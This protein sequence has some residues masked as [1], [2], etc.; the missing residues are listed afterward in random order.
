MDSFEAHK[1]NPIEFP[2]FSIKDIL[3]LYYSCPQQEKILQLYS[4]FIQLSFPLSGK[5]FWHHGNHTW[6]ASP[7]SG[8]LVKK[9]AFLQELPADGL[10][11]DVFVFYLKDEYL[12]S[13][14]HEFLPHLSLG[15]LPEPGTEMM[16]TF[17]IDD[18]IRRCYESLIPYFGMDKPLP[19]SILEGK[20]KELLFQIFSHKKNKHILSYVLKLNDGYQ[21]PLWQVM[22]ENY[23]YDLKIGDF[24]K[25]A[26]RSL[27]KFKR[28]F[29]SF[30]KEPPAKWVLKRR[31]QRAKSF[32]ETTDKSIRE[33]AFECGFSNPSHFSRVFKEYFGTPPSTMRFEPISKTIGLLS[34]A[35]GIYLS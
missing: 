3:F 23:M 11:W 2:Q 15:N 26:N 12:R 29:T 18:Q 17:E 4:K 9:C 14:F 20:F 28:D 10:G 19:E 24:A 8:I 32:L 22:E 33:I 30:Y 7:G 16:E 13:I 6:E 5:R 31:L 1:S 25:I 35:N 27:S 21:T 34:N